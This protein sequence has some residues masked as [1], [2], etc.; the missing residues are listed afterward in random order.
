MNYGLKIR[1]LVPLIAVA[2]LAGCGKKE[3]APPAPPAMPAKPAEMSKPAAPAAE[4]PKA[5]TD[6]VAAASSEA[7]GLIAKAKA[8]IAD[9]KYQDAANML[10]QLANTKLTPDQQKIVDDLKAQVQKYMAQQAVDKAGSE[11]SKAIGGL[12]K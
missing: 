7:D 12:L 5:A 6:A 2:V 3:E 1:V 10:T 4:A 8:L 9:K 11:A